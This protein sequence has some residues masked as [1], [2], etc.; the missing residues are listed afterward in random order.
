MGQMRTFI[1]IEVPD[2]VKNVVLG[3]INNLS[4]QDKGIRWVKPEGIHI[5]LKFLGNTDDVLSEKIIR[6]LENIAGEFSCFQ[7]EVSETGTFPSVNNPKVLWLGIGNGKNS[8]IQMSTLLENELEPLGFARENR[9]FHPHIT[10]GRV[11]DRKTGTR[12]IKG[13]LSFDFSP[14]KFTV[15][16]TV[17]KKSQ[18]TPQ[19][20]IYSDLYTAYLR[21]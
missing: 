2:E 1:A 12:I 4:G 6:I 15:K 11:K 21:E 7:L 18:L 14:V 20:A 13:F 17:W 9:P 16:S 8:L 3:Y 19:G 10:I 5:T